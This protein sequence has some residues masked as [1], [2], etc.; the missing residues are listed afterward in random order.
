MIPADNLTVTQ[1]ANRLHWLGMF[2]IRSEVKAVLE[3]DRKALDSAQ[4][5]IAAMRTSDILREILEE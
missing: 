3:R 4:Y 5:L 1:I 2:G